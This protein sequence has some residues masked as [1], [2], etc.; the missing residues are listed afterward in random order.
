MKQK[1]SKEKKQEERSQQEEEEGGKGN[2]EEEVVGGGDWVMSSTV[3]EGGDDSPATP[4][5]AADSHGGWSEATFFS[6][7]FFLFTV[8]AAARFAERETTQLFKFQRKFV[9]LEFNSQCVHP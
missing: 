5:I 9:L 4:A 3:E 2:T 7:P 1:P 8:I 6:F